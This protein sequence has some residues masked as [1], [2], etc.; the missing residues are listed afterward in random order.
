M[1]Q[2]RCDGQLFVWITLSALDTAEWQGSRK[3]CTR[4][5]QGREAQ[6]CC[7]GLH[8]LPVCV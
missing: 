3:G 4:M 2:M 6:G 5:P 8:D 7:A 1:D